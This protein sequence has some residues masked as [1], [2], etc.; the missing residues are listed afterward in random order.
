MTTKI[1][2]ELIDL[3][4]D[5]FHLAMT[6]EVNGVKLRMIL[7]TGASRTV[8]DVN[9]IDS[10]VQNPEMELNEQLS[11]G[12]GTNDM[13][14]NILQIDSFVIGELRIQEYSTVAIDMVHINQTYEILEMPLIDGVL[15]SDILHEFQAKIDYKTKELTLKF[16]KRKY[17]PLQH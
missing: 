5:G 16:H 14:S 10:F 11:T 3:N 4:G 7:D 9:R 6:V 13:Q 1:P 12:L 2:L 17:P 8:F 15:G